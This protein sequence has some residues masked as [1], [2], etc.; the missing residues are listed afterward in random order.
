M[1]NYIITVKNVIVTPEGNAYSGEIVKKVG[2]ELEYPDVISGVDLNEA[3]EPI[4]DED[5]V[6]TEET[7]E[8]K[9]FHFK[10]VSVSEYNSARTT[11][12]K[13]SKY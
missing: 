3:F 12:I 1:K 2:T 9:I 8:R 6:E 7:H 4:E 13:Y 10:E 11:F 5:D